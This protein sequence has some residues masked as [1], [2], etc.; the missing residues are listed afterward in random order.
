M[1]TTEPELEQC[2]HL[3][4]AYKNT[5]INTRGI[6]KHVLNKNSVY[7]SPTNHYTRRDFTF[8]D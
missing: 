8:I 7:I 5:D 2:K 3:A 1:D 4:L 6:L